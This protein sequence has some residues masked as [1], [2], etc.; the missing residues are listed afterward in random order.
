MTI[1]T[2]AFARIK[3]RIEAGE[4]ISIAD[5]G[6]EIAADPVARAAFAAMAEAS[7]AGQAIDYE[8]IERET[9]F[10]VGFIN[11]ALFAAVSGTKI[12]GA[13]L[14]HEHDGEVQ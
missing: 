4:A 12:V 8:Q 5:V 6:E 13:H 10:T 9:G 3:A 2:T 11:A 7:R 14:V 1:S